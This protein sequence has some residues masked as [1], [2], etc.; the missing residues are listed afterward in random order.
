I[1]ALDGD[2]FLS[3]HLMIAG[4]LHWKPAGAQ[5]QRR[6]GLAA[7]DFAHGTLTL[8][9]AATRKRAALHV[10][11][12]AAPLAALAPRGLWVVDW[13]VD[14]FSARLV[15]QDH[16]LKRTLTDPRLFS[17][18]GNAYSD[19]ILHAARLSPLQRS[20]NLDAAEIERLWRA[21][22]EIL[23]RWTER[24]RAEAGE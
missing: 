13:P 19:E 11:A 22:R 1:L 23:A 24:L 15:L 8:T 20:V 14:A 7:F 12:G 17:G 4:R 10:L 18:I 2:L 21:T 5:L 9:E 3:V 16:T 6:T